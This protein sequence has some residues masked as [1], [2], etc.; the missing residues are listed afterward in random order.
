MLLPLHTTNTSAAICY[1]CIAPLVTGFAAIGLFLFYFAYRYNFLFVYD[2]GVD[3]KGAGYPRALQQLFVGL[4]IAELCLLGLIGTRLDTAASVGPFVLMIILVVFTAF[5]HASLNAAL[6]PLIKYLPK[7]LEAEERQA[8]LASADGITTDHDDAEAAQPGTV[9][10]QVQKTEADT[11]V[12]SAAHD[13]GVAAGSAAIS[14]HKTPNMFVKFL[15]PHVY[16]DY[17]T[18]RRL[19]PSMVVPAD[20]FDEGFMR[21]AYLPPAVWAEMPQLLIPRDEIG[22]SRQECMDNEKVGVP[23]LD[24]A[25]RLDDKNKIVVE[26]DVMQGIYMGGKDQLIKAW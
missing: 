24:G 9:A 18:M 4:Y 21:D 3:M 16:N 13:D 10:P 12:S 19:V 6:T 2:A 7:T 1:S 22:V 8:L 15:K 17:S 20:A 26:D 25:A 11:V 14:P 23:C 5:Y